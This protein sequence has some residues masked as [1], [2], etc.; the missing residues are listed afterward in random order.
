MPRTM[1]PRATEPNK[2]MRFSQCC[3]QHRLSGVGRVGGPIFHT[4]AMTRR[5]SHRGELHPHCGATAPC[6]TFSQAGMASSPPLKERAA[7]LC[8]W[9]AEAPRPT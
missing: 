7:R 4:T 3:P 1:V 9:F 2:V 5:V 8:M 6:V